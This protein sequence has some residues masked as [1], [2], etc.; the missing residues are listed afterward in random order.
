MK[1]L[2]ILLVDDD[3]DDQMIFID[4]I[5]E[6]DHSIQCHVVG[7]GLEALLSLRTKSPSPDII[8]LDLNMP[9]MNGY[10]C[11]EEIKKEK[12]LKEI[13]VVIYTTSKLEAEKERTL[14]MGAKHFLI[15]P[16]DFSLLIKELSRILNLELKQD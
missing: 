5:K 10:E 13:P 2:N 14:Q 11:L 12:H 7:N 3:S 8:F 4:A 9:K 6:I 15:K 1:A 16:S